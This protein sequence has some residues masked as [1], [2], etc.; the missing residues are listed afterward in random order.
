MLFEV[1]ELAVNDCLPAVCE[2]IRLSFA[3][4]AEEL[5]LT[6][7][8]CQ[9]HPAF[10]SDS[11]LAESLCK[12]GVICF[13]ALENGLPVGFVAIWPKGKDAFAIDQGQPVAQDPDTYELTRLCVL[14]EHR[15]AGLGARLIHAALQAAKEHGAQKIEIGI[16]AEN[17]RLRRWYESH[18]F[19][20]TA[21]RE[22]GHLPFTVCEMERLL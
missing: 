16:I 21:V 14:P 7:Q 19:R 5:H 15:H 11:D 20:A 13:S 17:E 12:P 3:T 8:N 6:P 18:G 1:R 10:L 4:V 22:Y 2:I 9:Y